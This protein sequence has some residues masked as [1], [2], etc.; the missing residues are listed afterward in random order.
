[1]LTIEAPHSSHLHVHNSNALPF[2]IQIC[3]LETLGRRVP[4]PFGVRDA[5]HVRA[6]LSRASTAHLSELFH[7]AVDAIRLISL[8]HIAMTAQL[9][10]TVE[11]T[12]V[13]DVPVLLLGACVFTGENQLHS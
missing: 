5:L 13:E 10:V 12:E 3:A 2:S 8:D 4:V 6:D 7:V 1:M 11:A 9:Q